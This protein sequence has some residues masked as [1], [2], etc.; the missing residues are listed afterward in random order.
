[1]QGVVTVGAHDRHGVVSEW[2]SD[3]PAVTCS[4]SGVRV[5][6]WDPY[7]RNWVLGDGTSFASPSVTGLYE[8]MRV[9]G[10]VSDMPGFLR[11]VETRTLP[12]GHDIKAGWRSLEDEYQVAVSAC[13]GWMLAGLDAQRIGSLAFSETIWRDFAQVGGRDWRLP[14]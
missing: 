4:A 11:W 8:R 14:Q 6:V 5:Y 3:G 12:G 9:F 7:A 2:T 1:M 13:D 10:A